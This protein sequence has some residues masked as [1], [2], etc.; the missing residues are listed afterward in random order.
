[1]VSITA[2]KRTERPELLRGKGMIPG[3][4]Y[5]PKIDSSSLE[6]NEKVFHKIYAEAGESSLLD[7]EF[8]GEKIPVLIHEVQLDPLT[9]KSIHVDFYQPDLTKEV[10][11]QVPLIFEGEAP[12]VEELGGTLIHSIQEVDVKAL[13]QNLP[14]EIK[15]DV[16]VLRTFEDRIDVS[17]LAREATFEILQDKDDLVAQVVPAEDVEK[18]L[19]QSVEEDVE[20]VEKVEGEKGAQ[21]EEEQQEEQG[22]NS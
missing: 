5:G 8:E 15:V 13:P 22:E 12:A 2:H 1:M 9:S 7:L 16:T 18:E 14:H 19:E 20:G 10:E 3:V 4:L 17:D 11:V 6:V 21:G